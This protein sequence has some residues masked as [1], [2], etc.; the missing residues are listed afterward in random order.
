MKK[1]FR[2]LLILCGIVLVFLTYVEFTYHQKFEVP[3]TGIRASPDSSMIARGKY[4]V[5]GPSHCYACHTNDSLRQLK[6]KEPLMGGNV[7]KTPF[8]NF[9]MPNITMD[10]ETGIGNLSDED[11]ARAIRY[12]LNHKNEAMAGFMSYN[13][14]SDDDISAIISYLRTTTPVT[15]KVAAH[16]FNILGKVIARFMI[17]PYSD[18]KPSELKPDTTAE[19]GKYLAFT[20]GQ[21]NSCHTRRDKIGRFVGEPLA[22]GSSWETAEGTFTSPN[23][24]PDDSTGRITHW[25]EEVFV[26]RFRA[27]RAFK[28]SPMP[29][30]A[31]QNL[32]E[33]DLKAL[34]R[35]FNSLPAVK[36]EI[37]ATYIARPETKNLPEYSDETSSAV[38]N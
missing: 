6:L 20:V 35:Y 29:W 14:M 21:C 30:E 16:D 34:Y 22:G 15:N 18:P 5:L 10:K 38:G 36:N 3:V 31:Y 32:N 4:L 2:V 33:G 17:K 11:I 37:A 7:Y 25:T 8:G 28:G 24:T 9:N 12:N 27:G 13:D 26:T 23:L 1:T 19:Y